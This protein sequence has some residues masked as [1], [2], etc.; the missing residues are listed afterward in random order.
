MPSF[1]Q[2]ADVFRKA[3]QQ[4]L[5]VRNEND[6][7]DSLKVAQRLQCGL[8]HPGLC[9]RR[10]RADIAECLALSRKLTS[11]FLAA[12]NPTGLVHKLSAYNEAGDVE[13]E[14]HLMV[15]YVRRKDPQL[16]TFLDLESRAADTLGFAV[17]DGMLLVCF[18]GTVA[19]RA[20]TPTMSRVAVQLMEV[21]SPR[22][23]TLRISGVGGA[24]EVFTK[25]P[26]APAHAPAAAPAAVGRHEQLL[27]DLGAMIREGFDQ[28]P[29][30]RAPRAGRQPGVVDASLAELVGGVG[31][32]MLDEEEQKDS[33]SQG[34]NLSDLESEALSAAKLA[35]MRRRVQRVPAP[36]VARAA[37]GPAP[38]L[39][40]GV[41]GPAPAPDPDPISAPDGV[42]GVAAP[43]PDLGPAGLAAAV[44]PGGAA[45][46]AGARRGRVKAPEFLVTDWAGRHVGT[47]VW[48]R[49]GKSLDAHCICP[50]HEGG[51]KCGFN[52]TLNPR[53]LHA[54]GRPVGLLVAWLLASDLCTSRDEHFN[55]R[56]GKGPPELVQLVSFEARVDA[57]RLVESKPEWTEFL[58]S[59]GCHERPPHVDEGPEP[60]QLC[61]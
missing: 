5:F 7:P 20:Y 60:E 1:T 21:K 32:R 37:P 54:Q 59:A 25:H 53:G 46:A 43:A 34:S 8:A 41:A 30:H 9:K 47:V 35:A 3:L 12:A 18:V 22:L 50:A 51:L 55:L 2:Y 14:L 6:I 44:D 15:G 56:L 19:R 28:A 10:D 13:L 57:R 4:V 27:A 23:D 49:A 42:P 26:D 11:H 36:D 61:R 58:R 45:E 16:V 52:R 38:A 48:N 33:D 24:V 40:P 29:N 39:A 17:A 31:S